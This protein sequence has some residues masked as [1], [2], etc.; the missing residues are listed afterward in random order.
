MRLQA[1]V[2]AQR[3]M[4]LQIQ[5]ELK[6]ERMKRFDRDASDIKDSFNTIPKKEMDSRGSV[7]GHLNTLVSASRNDSFP[8]PDNEIKMTSKNYQVPSRKIKKSKSRSRSKSDSIISS[9]YAVN[10][11]MKK[12]SC[13]L[14]RKKSVPNIIFQKPKIERSKS[15]IKLSK[16]RESI[17]A[18]ASLVGNKSFDSHAVKNIKLKKS[19]R[20]KKKIIP[21]I[22]AMITLFC[23]Y[24]FQF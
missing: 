14:K 17:A 19:H 6:E 18:R 13:Q 16:S 7:L 11:S 10:K 9:S 4:I 1:L 3:K 20:S 2:E 5:G 12:T 24:F 8:E 15:K 22:K 23:F 21:S